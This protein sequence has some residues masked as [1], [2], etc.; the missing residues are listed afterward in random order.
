[1]NGYEQSRAITGALADLAE[2]GG[3]TYE[4]R[5]LA[6]VKP[7][8]GYAVGIGGITL[9][10]NTVN[11]EALAWAMD[12][13]AHGYDTDY[14]GTWLSDGVIFIDAVVLM[15]DLREAM[16]LALNHGQEAIYDF[17]SG[18]SLEVDAY[19]AADA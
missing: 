13:V 2:D 1:M 7:T 4:A 11:A 3:G 6:K 12:A 15:P 5:S 16:A 19:W 18:E 9:P 10:A 17:L 14:V 8:S